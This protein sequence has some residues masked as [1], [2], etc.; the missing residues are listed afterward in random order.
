MEH[1]LNVRELEWDTA[2]FGLACARIDLLDTVTEDALCIAFDQLRTASLVYITN[3]AENIENSALIAKHTDAFLVDTNIQF[4]KAITNV[5]P[6][7][8][9]EAASGY[10]GSQ[11]ILS[12][13]NRVYTKSRFISDKRLLS[14]RGQYMYGCWAENAFGRDDKFFLADLEGA[15]TRGFILF[16]QN[17][18][19]I[20]LELIGIDERF[21]GQGVGTNLWHCLEQEAA[22]RKRGQIRVGTQLANTQA[23]N[24]YHRMGC[25]ITKC[26]HIYHWWK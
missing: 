25:K 13:A 26:T 19:A 16:S 20:V 2:Y 3:L 8:L 23:I 4:E 22:R 10:P 15:Q 7:K 1:K 9:I 17:E 5:L 24:F 21:Q 11:D 14:R 12:I 18:D 6:K